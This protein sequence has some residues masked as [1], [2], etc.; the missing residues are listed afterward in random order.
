MRA[1]RV[2]TQ[3]LV[4]AANHRVDGE[5]LG[6]VLGIAGSYAIGK[7]SGW[8]IALLLE[9]IVPALRFPGVIGL[10]SGLYLAWK[11]SRMMPIDALRYE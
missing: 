9:P 2:F 4:E 1:R 10:L 8:R 3:F 5:L 7:I 6:V 11:A